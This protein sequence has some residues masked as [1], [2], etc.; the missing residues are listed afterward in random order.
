MDEY[1]YVACFEWKDL[2]GRILRN[3]VIFKRYRYSVLLFLVYVKK[4]I[5]LLK[6]IRGHITMLIYVNTIYTLYYI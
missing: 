6:L 5:N 3:V 2:R 4:I 1:I